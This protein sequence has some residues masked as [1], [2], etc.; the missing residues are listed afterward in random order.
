MKLKTITDNQNDYSLALLMARAEAIGT[1][2][3]REKS[4][5]PKWFIKETKNIEMVS[6]IGEILS[7]ASIFDSKYE[8]GSKF[9]ALSGTKKL[10][11]KGLPTRAKTPKGPF[12]KKSSTEEVY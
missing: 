1:G 5:W 3:T 11:D 4:Q 10:L 7:E 9:L 2:N 6:R 12:T 8:E